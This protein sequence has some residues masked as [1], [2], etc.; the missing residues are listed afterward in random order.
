MTLQGL[1]TVISFL[2]ASSC[3]YTPADQSAMNMLGGLGCHTDELIHTCCER[4]SVEDEI[5]ISLPD[6]SRNLCDAEIHVCGSCVTFIHLDRAR[7]QTQ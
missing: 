7:I 6:K 5:Y 2:G 4:Y 3:N 1:S